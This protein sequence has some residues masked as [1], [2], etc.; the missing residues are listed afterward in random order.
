M[1]RLNKKKIKKPHVK[2]YSYVDTRGEKPDYSY[3]YIP[4]NKKQKYHRSQ[5][6]KL[7]AKKINKRF[8]A[9][10]KED[11]YT[12]I[13]SE[14]WRMLKTNY[15][16]YMNISPAERR[17]VSTS[18]MRGYQYDRFTKV[19]Y[20]FED[21]CTYSTQID[22]VLNKINVIRK[23]HDMSDI[24]KRSVYD[25]P[26][27]YIPVSPFRI[28]WPQTVTQVAGNEIVIKMDESFENV[29]NKLNEVSSNISDA[30]ENINTAAQN[31]IAQ[32]NN[33][34]QNVNA[35]QN[36]FINVGHQEEENLFDQNDRSVI[37]YRND[38]KLPVTNSDPFVY[39]GS[40]NYKGLINGGYVDNGKYLYVPEN[41]INVNVNQNMDLRGVI[42]QLEQLITRMN[43]FDIGTNFGNILKAINGLN[44]QLQQQ[45]NK[46]LLSD[47][48]NKDFNSLIQNTQKQ[49]KNMESLEKTFT[50]F[51]N[52][53]KSTQ[54]NDQGN[55]ISKL[56][57]DI[58]S[59]VDTT[60]KMYTDIHDKLYSNKMIEE[61]DIPQ[62]ELSITKP[63]NGFRVS[64]SDIG[65]IYE[66][67][68]PDFKMTKEEFM[69]YIVEIYDDLIK[70]HISTLDA[71]T[72]KLK[73][74]S[75]LQNNGNNEQLVAIS[76][77]FESFITAYNQSYEQYKKLFDSINSALGIVNTTITTQ[78][79]KMIENDSTNTNRL[80][81]DNQLTRDSNYYNAL[82]IAQTVF[83]TSKLIT[84]NVVSAIDRV[85]N[86]LLDLPK[87]TELLIQSGFENAQQYAQIIYDNYVQ[88]INRPLRINLPPDIVD[89][90][91]S[92]ASMNN[93]YNHV[94]ILDDNNTDE[95][96]I[97][98]ADQI[99]YDI[100]EFISF[101]YPY[102]DNEEFIQFCRSL[103]FNNMFSAYRV[104]DKY[105]YL[106]QLFSKIMRGSPFTY[107]ELQQYGNY[108]TSLKLNEDNKFNKDFTD[109]VEKMLNHG[110]QYIHK[111]ENY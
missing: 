45:T 73:N 63:K 14:R 69:D 52:L 32:Q 51:V 72:Q 22:P 103:G 30:A 101:L 23:L 88:L 74:E 94:G 40:R 76:T 41:N 18:N 54:Q 75:I 35:Q 61:E 50:D 19:L 46:K 2:E 58:K 78:T 65:G 66:E 100:Y 97:V 84:A 42:S 34:Q 15:D 39:R 53:M 4:I 99:R 71:Y 33:M 83:D 9:V 96:R 5:T 111:I 20:S 110:V 92:L 10:E 12:N 80:L 11:Y 47:K 26:I 68:S 28:K 7:L 25:N 98:S 67:T 6:R 43:S 49:L 104:R 29:T 85:N 90:L 16:A 77:K 64:T 38:G 48:V 95:Q 3:V 31:I 17:T 86:T 107:E 89:A 70:K 55:N 1:N 62:Q 105:E 13:R 21:N 106:Q 27:K 56:I 59:M 102:R 93:I 8:D 87:F 79:D 109:F 60:N 57:T 81:Q 37:H 82:G 36:A 91:N 24:E 108:I 44:T